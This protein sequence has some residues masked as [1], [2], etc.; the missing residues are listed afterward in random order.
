VAPPA[1]VGS[2]QSYGNSSVSYTFGSRQGRSVLNLQITHGGRFLVKASG[3]PT[4]A[5][6]SDLAFGP[7]F[8]GGI[9]AVVLP[10]LGL[11]LAGIAAAI[12][13]GVVRSSRIRRA[14][15][16]ALSPAA[17]SIDP[18]QSAQ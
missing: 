17:P 10:S 6:G 13:L 1:E 2:L 8:A 11:I 18:W 16:A 9:L 5:G 4:L 15:T 14:R 3:A 12:T 7:D